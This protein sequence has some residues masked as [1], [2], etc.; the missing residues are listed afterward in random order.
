MRDMSDF[1]LV[2]TI[3]RRVLASIRARE[4]EYAKDVREWY[5]EGDGQ[6][7]NWVAASTQEW[8]DPEWD[9]PDRMVNIGGRGYSYPA[10]IHGSSLW[11][12]YDN[13]CGGCEDSTTATRAAV[14]IADG[15]VREFNKRLDW[16]SAAPRNLPRELSSE[17]WKYVCE[18]VN[19]Y[20]KV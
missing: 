9:N 15:I 6:S 3:A 10:C 1:L 2:L 5:E 20:P 4:A 16:A 11:T 14:E 18:P 7:P 12:D 13:I 19:R 8:F 17:I